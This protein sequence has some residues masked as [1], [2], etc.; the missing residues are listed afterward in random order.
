MRLDLR[1]GNSSSSDN[2]LF[3]FGR[4]AERFLLLLLLAAAEEEQELELEEVLLKPKEARNAAFLRIFS[5]R[6]FS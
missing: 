4:L 3:F 2:A 1:I 6:T 5:R